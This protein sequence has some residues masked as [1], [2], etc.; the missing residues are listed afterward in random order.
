M[1]DYT[2]CHTNCHCTTTV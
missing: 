1:K 2:L